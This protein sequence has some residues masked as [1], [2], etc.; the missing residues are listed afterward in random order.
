ME[1][2]YEKLAKDFAKK[3]GIKLSFIGEPE[4]RKHFN[5]DREPRWVFKCRLS[6]NGKSYTFN[7]GQSIVNGGEY[8]TL[9]SALA[10]LTKYDVGGFED[11]CN[12][13]GFDE[14]SRSAEKTYKAVLKEWKAVKRLFSDILEELSEIS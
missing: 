13:F 9:Y 12:E 5:I 2:N 1:A 7:F 8:P 4:Y 14:D 3:H 11:F 10:C 6:R